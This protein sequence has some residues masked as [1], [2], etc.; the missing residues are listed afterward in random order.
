MENRIIPINLRAS[1]SFKTRQDSSCSKMSSSSVFKHFW[2][3]LLKQN[4]PYFEILGAKILL[5]IYP[6][7]S[8]IM[9]ECGVIF[10]LTLHSP[11]NVVLKKS[12]KVKDR[13]P[14][15]LGSYEL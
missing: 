12:N 5:Q 8:E 14:K 1:N 2:E 13:L 11:G 4:V 6:F 10:S 15:D 9:D 3:H 7:F